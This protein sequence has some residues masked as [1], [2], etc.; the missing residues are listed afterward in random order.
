MGTIHAVPTLD[1]D[2][3]F[4]DWGYKIRILARRQGFDGDMLE[5]VV[6]DIQVALFKGEYLEK[7]DPDMGDFDVYIFGNIRY[8][9]LAARAKMFK[10]G[11]REVVVQDF[12]DKD[13]SRR[14]EDQSDYIHV[15]EV[16][17][18]LTTIHASLTKYPAT[19]TK[20]LA[21][22]FRDMIEQVRD[23][24]TSPDGRVNLQAIADKYGYSK[25]AIHAQVKTLLGTNEL[26]QLKSQLERKPTK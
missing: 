23:G 18:T 1:Y 21:R 17:E 20:D 22:L 16:S 13:Q 7:Y 24:Q 3:F 15:I 26:K 9:L 25:Q 11:Q 19:K 8:F 2:E 5:E 12:F 4:N 6:Q 14:F 10:R